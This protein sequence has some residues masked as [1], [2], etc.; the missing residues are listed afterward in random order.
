[1]KKLGL[2]NDIIVDVYTKEIRSVLEFGAP[3]WTGALTERDSTKFERIQKTTLKIVLDHK[4]TDYAS[5][6]EKVK[7]DLLKYRREKLCIKFS[8][9]GFKKSNSIFHKFTSK[10]NTRH[11]KQKL[12]SEFKCNTGRYFTSGLPFLS[13]LLN[14]ADQK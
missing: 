9:I 2:S 10:R 5:A 13:R 11:K 8:K 7:L 1:M 3:I 12:V 6:C 4:F 14:K